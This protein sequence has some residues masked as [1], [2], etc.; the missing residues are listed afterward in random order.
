MRL[1]AFIPIFSLFMAC[2]S[3]QSMNGNGQNK[4]VVG[5][6]P[7]PAVDTSIQPIVSPT[8]VAMALASCSKTLSPTIGVGGFEDDGPCPVT[9]NQ[10]GGPGGAFVLFYPQTMGV[11]GVKHPVL[12]WGNGTLMLPVVYTGI[13]M[14]LASHGFV[15]IASKSMLTGDGQT[16]LQGVSW[17][18]QEATRQ[19]SPFY[20]VIDTMR[21][22]AVGHSQGGTGAIE[23][24]KDPRLK[25]I[26]SIQPGGGDGAAL[27]GQS[28][29][30][31]GDQDLINSPE[32]VHNVFLSTASPSFFASLKEGRHLTPMGSGSEMRGITTAWL[33]MILMNDPQAARIFNGSDCTL[34]QDQAWRIERRGI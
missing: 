12:T 11:N 20:G 21:I 28:L 34:C 23:A 6:S 30:I 10:N 9:V 19:G 33:R 2:A 17:M 27:K 24:G 22:G 18:I 29:V 31:A 15:V 14:H 3:Q 4:P 13:L 16:M 5:P 25:A 8:P 1:T 7:L 26:V 32:L